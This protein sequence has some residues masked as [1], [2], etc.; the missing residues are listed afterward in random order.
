MP[1]GGTLFLYNRRVLRFFRKD[2]HIWRRTKDGRTIREAHEHLKVDNVPVLSCYYAHGDENPLFQRRSYW[3]LDPAYEHIVLVHYRDV[4]EGRYFGMASSS[5][6]NVSAISTQCVS[7]VTID[8]QGVFN[9]CSYSPGYVENKPYERGS[10]IND[11]ASGESTGSGSSSRE[12]EAQVHEALRNLEQHLISD[13]NPILDDQLLHPLQTS[14]CTQKQTNYGRKSELPCIPEYIQSSPDISPDIRWDNSIMVPLTEPAAEGNRNKRE[15]QLLD[16]LCPRAEI[17]C[18]W[19]E[20][21]QYPAYTISETL[22][23]DVNQ[24]L[25]LHDVE[26]QEHVMEEI[27]PEMRDAYSAFYNQQ[28]VQNRQLIYYG[29]QN[30]DFETVRQSDECSKSFLPK[31]INLETKNPISIILGKQLFC[32]HEISPE[33]AFSYDDNST[34]VLIL[35]DFLIGNYLD[36]DWKVM[37]GNVQVPAEV[38]QKDMLRCKA[39]VHAPGRVTLCLTI[40]NWESCSEIREFEFLEKPETS[41]S[42]RCDQNQTNCEWE[43]LLLLTKFTRILLVEFQNDGSSMQNSFSENLMSRSEQWDHIIESLMNQSGSTT[44]IVNW[45]LQ[46]L[47]KDKLMQRLK[48]IGLS[49]AAP[50]RSLSMEEKRIIHMISGLG[51]LWALNPMLE[52]GIGVNFRDQ[53]GWTALHWAARFG[54]EEM[55]SALLAAGASAGAITDPSTRDP[56]GMTA[57]SIAEAN[58]H[59]GLAGYLSEISLND[60]LAALTMEH[61]EISKKSTNLITQEVNKRSDVNEW[62][63]ASETEDQISLKYSLEAARSAAQAA[64]RIQA[65]FRAHSFRM[66]REKASQQAQEEFCF[67][68]SEIQELSRA[69]GALYSRNNQ[70]LLMAVMCIQKRFRGWRNRG[71]FL[72][73]RHHAVK[74]QARIRGF[75]ARKRYREFLWTVS[76]F[77]KAVLRWRRGGSGLRGFN[78]TSEANDEIDDED[79]LKVFRRQKVDAALDVAVSRVLSMAQS[80]EARQ[81]YRRMVESYWLRK[82]EEEIGSRSSS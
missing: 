58:G 4:R 28:E 25:S 18:T 59:Q 77:E 23:T 48:G 78:A 68:P 26:V 33:R 53:K 16:E 7:P 63:H 56:I 50:D 65:A 40:G 60:H 34:Q 61:S 19:K 81:Q 71:N 36:F 47:L 17:P 27:N 32:I 76:I 5:S 15:V 21:L 52:A 8:G 6:E 66:K 73:L 46:E 79:I 9:L 29:V 55:V 80:R 45:L 57:A 14:D 12:C 44:G 49:D 3:M 31:Q 62:T 30:E 13:Y 24:N 82:L 72:K 67:T 64:A 54:R 11:H 20:P 35:G 43:E 39:P 22:E 1:P 70:K 69:S 74:I 75:L 41:G 38:I 10:M 51:F 37:F 42:G 2:G